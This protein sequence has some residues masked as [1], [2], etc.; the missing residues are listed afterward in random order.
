VVQ[1]LVVLGEEPAAEQRTPM[2]WISGANR[3]WKGLSTPLK[4]V[5]IGVV[6][7]IGSVMGATVTVLAWNAGVIQE[8]L[9]ITKEDMQAQ[10]DTLM[11]M[12]DDQVKEVIDEAIFSY[13]LLLREHLA[14]ERKLAVDTAYVP[15]L[16]HVKMLTEV[17]MDVRKNGKVTDARVQELPREFDEQL[18]RMIEAVDPASD[19][20]L[21]N[22]VMRQNAE[23][24]EQLDA[25]QQEL[26]TGRRT[27]KMK[28]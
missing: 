2:S 4:V 10:T 19:R 28:L 26:K 17:V 11:T 16:R 27:S 15:L 21:M 7:V 18:T 1:A 25:L 23:M 20:E 3:I 6:L 13:D 9:G 14:Q 5:A 12:R 22:E 24:K 8:K